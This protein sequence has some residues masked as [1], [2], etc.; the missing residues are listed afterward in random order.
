[1]RTKFIA[2]LVIF[3]VLGFSEQGYAYRINHYREAEGIRA[4][5]ARRNIRLIPIA[6]AQ[7]IAAGKVN[8]SRVSFTNIELDNEAE[9]YKANSGFL[10]VYKMEY[11]ADGHSFRIE[12]DASNGTTLYLNQEY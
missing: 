1:M 6:F 12:I 11:V 2:L 7:T 4:E 8:S 5:A 9:R 3:M 10:P